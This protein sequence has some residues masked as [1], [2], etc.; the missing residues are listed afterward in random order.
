[1]QGFA[2]TP[3]SE[4][5]KESWEWLVCACFGAHVVVN[6][7]RGLWFGVGFHDVFPGSRATTTL[8]G[9]RGTACFIKYSFFCGR[10][11]KARVYGSAL[12][13]AILAKEKHRFNKLLNA[14]IYS[15]RPAD[16][17][18]VNRAAQ[19]Q[20]LHWHADEEACAQFTYK[21]SERQKG[22]LLTHGES[23]WRNII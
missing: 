23:I 21:D 7:K 1:V 12:S 2:F 10:F 19:E 9:S 13:I 8:A 4:G 17:F 11:T 15:F 6:L 3:F 5:L 20:T 18:V 16:A 14:R 22:A